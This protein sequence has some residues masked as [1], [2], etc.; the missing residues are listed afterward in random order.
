MSFSLL[1]VASGCQVRNSSPQ[2]QRFRRMSHA[3]QAACRRTAMVALAAFTLLAMAAPSTSARSG[4]G[5]LGVT[6]RKVGGSNRPNRQ[7]TVWLSRSQRYPTS[8]GHGLS[9]D[10]G[11]SFPHKESCVAPAASDQV[12]RVLLTKC[13]FSCLALFAV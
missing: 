8:T 13:E 9:G 10:C 3:S 7:R 11:Q 6:L 4:A 12:F 5:T 1:S 2:T